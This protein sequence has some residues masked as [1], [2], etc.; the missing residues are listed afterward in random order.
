[1]ESFP[2]SCSQKG[3]GA[4]IVALLQDTISQAESDNSERID[5][6]RS[7]QDVISEIRQIEKTI[8]EQ[9]KQ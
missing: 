9:E 3:E 8:K 7:S 2:H 6:D 4:F 1:M 5:T